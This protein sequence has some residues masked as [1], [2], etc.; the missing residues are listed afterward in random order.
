MR[1]PSW[2]GEE[3]SRNWKEAQIT[4]LDMAF[5]ENIKLHEWFVQIC[6]FA[7]RFVKYER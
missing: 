2:A 4:F 1:L 5:D 7:K 6:Q 3:G